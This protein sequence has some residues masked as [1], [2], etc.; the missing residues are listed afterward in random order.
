MC[1]NFSS[2]CYWSQYHS[3]S[4]ATVSPIEVRK[5]FVKC[6]IRSFPIYSEI[7]YETSLKA[8]SFSS[9]ELYRNIGSFFLK[10]RFLFALIIFRSR[11]FSTTS[12]P[13]ASPIYSF[14]LAFSMIVWH[15]AMKMSSR[16]RFLPRCRYWLVSMHE[17]LPILITLFEIYLDY[18]LLQEIWTDI[19]SKFTFLGSITYWPCR[20]SKRLFNLTWV[21]LLSNRSEILGS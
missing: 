6:Y 13:W 14:Y 16:S 1:L 15:L 12:M 3:S 17:L 9:I 18:L 10:I 19:V 4:E 8:Q 2:L 20:I 5:L 7:Y 21:S 11:F